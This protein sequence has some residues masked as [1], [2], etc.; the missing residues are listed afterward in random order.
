MSVAKLVG[1]PGTPLPSYSVSNLFPFSSP[2]SLYAGTCTQN[3]PGTGPALANVTV[4][5]GG[6]VSAAGPIQLP[7][8]QLTVH[9]GDTPASPG[10]P[11]SG[12]KVTIKDLATGC[13]N[14]VRTFTS[15]VSGQLPNPGLPYGT[16]EVCSQ[17]SFGSIQRRNYVNTTSAPSAK[18][19]VPVQNTSAGTVRDIYLG[20]SAPLIT[21]GVGA[22]CP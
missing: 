21:T 3:N 18:E 10:S 8:L 7:A 11:V 9:S 22:T 13:G 17:A 6:S 4:P 15:N 19:A 12:A 16:Y 2:Y 20:T 5:A 1:T 14:L